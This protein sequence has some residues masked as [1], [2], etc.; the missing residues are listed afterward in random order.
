MGAID[1]VL[2]AAMVDCLQVRSNMAEL[3]V[4]VITHTE[5][6]HQEV[7]VGPGCMMSGD[8]IKGISILRL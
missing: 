2:P 1:E 4:S 3:S 7:P 6:H 8:N 5:R